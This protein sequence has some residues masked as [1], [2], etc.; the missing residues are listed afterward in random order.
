[1]CIHVFWEGARWRA[2]GMGGKKGRRKGGFRCLARPSPP[3]VPP[4]LLP[5]PAHQT[6]LEPK[7]EAIRCVSFKKNQIFLRGN[8]KKQREKGGKGRVVWL[9]GLVLTHHPCQRRRAPIRT[10][11]WACADWP[12]FPPGRGRGR[13][14]K[15]ERTRKRNHGLGCA[16]PNKR[17]TLRQAGEQALCASSSPTPSPFPFSPLFFY[18]AGDTTERGR[19]QQR[20]RRQ[21]GED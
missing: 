19:R 5:V 20:R 11:V 3:F 9:A 21:E 12:S 14:E 1:M 13:G 7:P 8:D 15:G 4:L 16:C 6:P 17:A 10:S 2:K 18:S